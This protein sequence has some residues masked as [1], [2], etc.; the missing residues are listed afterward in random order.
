MGQF[1][2]STNRG[3]KRRQS[4]AAAPKSF[5][6]YIEQQPL[7]TRRLLYQFKFVPG[8]ERALKECLQKNQKIRA[9]SD[10]SLN[11]ETQYSSFGWLIIANKCVLVEGAGPVDGVPT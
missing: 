9:A 5:A 2:R 6:E 10:G 7:T 11:K 4:T 1:A 8:G 3:T